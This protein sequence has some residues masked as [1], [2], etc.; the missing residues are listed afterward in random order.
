MPSLGFADMMR[1]EV[2]GPLGHDKYQEYAHDIHTGG[3]E[4]LSHIADILD[5]SQ[6]Q[7]GEVPIERQRIDLVASVF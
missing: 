6:I 4:L 7:S 3:T 2:F 5:V 1:S